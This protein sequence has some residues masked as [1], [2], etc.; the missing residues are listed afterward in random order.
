[1][2]LP[3]IDGERKK[4]LPSGFI[5]GF[6]AYDGGQDHDIIT[7]HD[8]GPIGLLGNPSGLKAPCVPVQ[9]Q[10]YVLTLFHNQPP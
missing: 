7:P 1:M 8:G 10:L 5:R 9:I 6:T 2:A 3:V 4:V